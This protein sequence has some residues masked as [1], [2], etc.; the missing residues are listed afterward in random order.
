MSPKGAAAVPA[1]LSPGPA[2]KRQRRVAA[3]GGSDPGTP[4]VPKAPSGATPTPLAVT[5]VAAL[6]CAVGTQLLALH[7]AE[8]LVPLSDLGPALFNRHGNRQSGAHVVNLISQL[9][10]SLGFAPHVYG[11]IWCI[12]WDPVNPLAVSQWGNKMRKSD[13]RLPK[14]PEKPLYGVF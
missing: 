4:T 13:S 7:P 3:S 14:L 12:K 9:I 2:A 8:T 6:P 5:P 11:H 1:A 10:K